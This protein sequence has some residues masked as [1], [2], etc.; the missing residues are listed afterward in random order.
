MS[1]FRPDAPPKNLAW[2]AMADMGAMELISY[3]PESLKNLDVIHRFI[4]NGG[5][6]SIIAVMI[7]FARIL[8]KDVNAN[9][10]LKMMQATMERYGYKGWTV[11]QHGLYFPTARASDLIAIDGFRNEFDRFPDLKHNKQGVVTH[12]LFVDFK[13]GIYADPEG[14]D[15]LNFKRCIDYASKHPEE[16]LTYPE[17]YAQILQLLGG[18]SA[19]TTM[20]GDPAVFKRWGRVLSAL[21]NTTLPKTITVAPSLVEVEQ[22]NQNAG[23]MFLHGLATGTDEEVDLDKE[24]PVL[25]HYGKHYDAGCHH[26]TNR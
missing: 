12:F 22:Q 10:I 9:T 3:H 2:P 6:P 17:H 8:Q 18:S 15:A 4:K 26:G 21:N 20:H 11:K 25:A 23:S 13:K 7:N 5:T 24:H 14:Y 16:Q 19:I 1:I